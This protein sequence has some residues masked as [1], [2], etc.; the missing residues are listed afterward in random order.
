MKLTGK[1]TAI[2]DFRF[3]LHVVFV[4]A[5]NSSVPYFNWFAERSKREIEIKFSFVCLYPT[6][7][8]MLDDMKALGCDCY[9]VRYDSNNRK[10]SL[11]GTIYPLYRLFT[12]IK[13][14]VV[15][16]HLF[17]DSLVSLLA[18][19]LA[20]VEVRAITKADTGFHYKYTPKWVKFDKFNNWNATHIVA[21]S[22]ECKDFVLEKENADP[23]KVKLIHHGIPVDKFT[24]Q[25]DEYKKYLKNKYN[26]EGKKVIGTV[27]RLIE[28]KGYRY[29]IKAASEVVK[30]YPNAVFLFV[31]TGEQ[32]SE[33]KDIIVENRMQDNI[34]LAGWIDRKMMPS[35]YGVLDVYLH[36]ATNEPFGFVIAEAMMNGCAVVSTPTGAAKDS[37]VDKRNGILV[38]YRNSI[39]MAEAV[40]YILDNDVSS[41]R[42]EAKKT[43]LNLFPFQKMWNRHLAL[44]RN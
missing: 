22:K 35:L 42:R 10:K 43:A 18:S 24:D 36:A 20:Q 23:S 4:M 25:R 17:D 41:I 15:H 11:L 3:M 32:E 39:E 2:P 7:P 34:I 29:I 5:N 6:K 1:L 28:W 27:S 19:R 38:S 30:S 16:G 12:K 26:L 40:I 31:G 13:P 8:Q 33:L 14:D 9:W 44:Y 37:I 21:I